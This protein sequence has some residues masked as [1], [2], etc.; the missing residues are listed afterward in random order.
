MSLLNIDRILAAIAEGQDPTD[1]GNEYA[2]AHD[3][4]GRQW[5]VRDE[6]WTLITESDEDSAALYDLRRDPEESYNLA[7]GHPE[8]VESLRRVLTDRV[9]VESGGIA[10]EGIDET[11]ESHMEA[12]GYE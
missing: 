7:H 1:T 4:Q 5:A 12:L 3:E 6:R 2:L 10:V 8:P 11:L 9:E